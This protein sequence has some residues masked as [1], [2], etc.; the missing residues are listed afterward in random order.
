MGFYPSEIPSMLPALLRGLEL[1][2]AATLLIMAIGL[3]AGL[4]VALARMSRSWLL[5]VPA[6]IYVQ[7]LRGTPVLLQLFYL[8]YVL[9]FAGIRL[10]AWTAGIIGMSAA[11][12]AYL[13]EIYRAGIEAVDRGQT[14]AALSIGMS[15]VQVMRLVILP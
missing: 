10:P 13:S 15:R 1:T 2:V 6:T 5:R 4:P 7:V 9:P 3:A 14:E 8:Y 11:Y 12:T